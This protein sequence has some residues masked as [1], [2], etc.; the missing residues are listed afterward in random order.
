M[1]TLLS[2]PMVTLPI[3]EVFLVPVHAMEACC[4]LSIATETRDEPVSVDRCIPWHLLLKNKPGDF[5]GED[6]EMAPL[7]AIISGLKAITH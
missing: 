1:A 6:R 2:V 7:G 4:G 3:V 5:S